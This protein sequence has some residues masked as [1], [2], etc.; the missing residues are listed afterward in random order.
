MLPQRNIGSDGFWVTSG[1][2]KLWR[3]FG[4]NTKGQLKG[5]VILDEKNP[6][7][8]LKTII[9]NYQN[10][11]KDTLKIIKEY[12]DISITTEKY[13][14]EILNLYQKMI[15][16]KKTKKKFSNYTY[17]KNRNNFWIKKLSSKDEYL[18][19]F[20]QIKDKKYDLIDKIE[21][22]NNFS[23]NKDWLDNL[24]LQTQIVK[25]DSQLNYQHG[26]VVYSYLR[27]YL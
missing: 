12:H 5:G 18:K 7:L 27:K 4:N 3:K 26:R 9:D 16:F 19:L 13:K 1:Y 21:K 10:F 22:Q 2:I 17:F 11:Q 24:A 15:I 14:K 23:L 6:I 8:S 25:K 20:Y